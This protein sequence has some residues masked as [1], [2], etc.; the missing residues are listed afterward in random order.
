VARF[1]R[2]VIDELLSAAS[3]TG[4]KLREVSAESI[5]QLR[6][7]LSDRFGDGEHM[8]TFENMKHKMALQDEMGWSRLKG[9]L[10]PSAHVLFYD[11]P[12]SQDR[13][14]VEVFDGTQIPRLI[15]EC[16][17]FPFYVTNLS[18]DF[19]VGMNDHDFLIG[20]GMARPWIASGCPQNTS[21]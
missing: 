20:V 15:E 11:S 16:F 1:D 13:G 21:E 9:F 5:M 14:G 12:G 2:Y 7:E 6:S 8:L 10:R 17:G 18:R 19:V 3:R 4:V